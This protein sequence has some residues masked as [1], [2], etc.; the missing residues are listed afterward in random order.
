MAEETTINTNQNEEMDG[1]ATVGQQAQQQNAQQ[2]PAAQSQQQNASNLRT[3]TQEQLDAIIARERNKAIKGMFTAEQMA[4]KDTSIASL[5]TERDTA[6]ASIAQLQAE[7][8]GY[9]HE[10]LLTGKGVPADM[11]EFYAFKIGKLVSKDKT[12]EQAAEDY[13]KDNPPAGTVRMSTGGGVGAAAGKQPSINDTMNA[14]IRGK[15]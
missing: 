1:G 10:K 13:L 4:A 12:F 15:K 2:Q 9:K 11:V 8:D 14:L 5:T 7:L 3:F 6:N